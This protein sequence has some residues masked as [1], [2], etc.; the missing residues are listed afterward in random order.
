MYSYYVTTLIDRSRP[1]YYTVQFTVCPEK[2]E[3]P[4]ILHWQVQTCPVLNKIKHALAQKYL[5]Y[6]RQISYDSIIPFNRFSI[7]TNCYHRFQL[8]TLL[9]YYARHVTHDV[10]LLI[11]KM[12]SKEDRILIKVLRV[13]KGYGAKR[14]AEFP[15]CFHEIRLTTRSGAF[16][17]S[18]SS[19][20]AGSV[21]STIWKNN[22]LQNG[23]NLTRTSLTAVNQW[24]ER[25]CVVCQRE[26]RTL[27]ASNLNNQ[28]I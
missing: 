19:T 12:L 15:A 21:T 23:A 16:C 4:N 22:W 9:T 8:P 18:E 27:S 13:E 11:N 1:N 28:T 26:Q 14:M 10:I 7:F 3:P 17:K 5:S 2:S 20:V 24:W 25:L 6:C